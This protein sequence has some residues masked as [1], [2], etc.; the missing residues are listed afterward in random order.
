MESLRWVKSV[1]LYSGLQFRKSF[2]SHVVGFSHQ[3]CT[4]GEATSGVFTEHHK[5]YRPN[6]GHSCQIT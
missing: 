5:T 4:M 6:A 1:I 3:P 2:H